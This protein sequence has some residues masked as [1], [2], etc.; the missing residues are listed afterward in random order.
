MAC[1]YFDIHNSRPC[2]AL[3]IKVVFFFNFMYISTPISES[4]SV[5][6]CLLHAGVH[7]LAFYSALKLGTILL[8]LLRVCL[9]LVCLCLSAAELAI[10][11]HH[12]QFHDSFR[13]QTNAIHH[14]IPIVCIIHFSDCRCV[15]CNCVPVFFFLFFSQG[16]KGWVED[17]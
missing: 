12:V 16:W 11:Q 1:F 6:V 15:H 7:Q 4:L 13:V 9:C 17:A 2:F 8:W 14:F 10:V 3:C 5:I